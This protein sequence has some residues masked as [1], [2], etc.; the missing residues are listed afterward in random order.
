MSY[1]H[2]PFIVEETSTET[3][4]KVLTSLSWRA[5]AD[6]GSLAPESVN[7][8]LLWFSQVMISVGPGGLFTIAA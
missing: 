5:G 4:N 2:S 1:H 8:P 6:Q 7:P 3:L